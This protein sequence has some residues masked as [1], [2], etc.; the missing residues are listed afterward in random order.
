MAGVVWSGGMISGGE[1]EHLQ[2]VKRR[3][4]STAEEP[5]EN[6]SKKHG[7]ENEMP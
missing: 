2:L 5:K 6:W 7:R 3:V 4:L 1:D